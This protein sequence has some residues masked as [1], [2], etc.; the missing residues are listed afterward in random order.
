MLPEVQ[1]VTRKEDWRDLDLNFGRHPATGDVSQLKGVN[2]ISRSVRNLIL[3]HFYD[4]K[5]NPQV[6]SNATKMLFEPMGPLTAINLQNVIAETVY[7][8]EPRCNLVDITVEPDYDENG[9]K[10][11][12]TFLPKN[13]LTPVTIQLFL[14]RLR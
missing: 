8:F 6:G 1:K 14:E 13:I 7:K 11:Q 4:K 5:F 2:A 10:A 9:Y 3:M 12:I